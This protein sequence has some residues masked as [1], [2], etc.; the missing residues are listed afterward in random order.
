MP[1][2]LKCPVF[3][4]VGGKKSGKT[5][6]VEALVK[7]LAKRQYRIGTV[8]HVSEQ[9]FTIDREGKDSWRFA[10]AGSKTN[11][12]VASEEL[13]T[14]EKLQTNRLSID[15]ILDRFRDTDMVFIEGL[16]KIVAMDKRVPKIVVV[17]SAEDL[18][19][20]SKELDPILAFTGLYSAERPV[21]DIPY[22]NALSDPARLADLVE[23][24]VR[25]KK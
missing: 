10:Q 3:G 18:L 12:T 22:V 8:K 9:G 7:E 15:D 24:S 11:I 4:V 13:A 20:A 19:R 23:E 17:K 25:K 5:T 1:E 2:N 6:V 14:V 21:N 16:R